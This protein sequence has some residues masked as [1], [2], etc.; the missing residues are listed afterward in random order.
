MLLRIALQK[1]L[2]VEIFFIGNWL[3]VRRMGR[4]YFFI[5]LWLICIRC[6]EQIC[7]PPTDIL[8]TYFLCLPK[9]LDF[10]NQT[11][12]LWS[13]IQKKHFHTPFLKI[14]N[15]CAFT[16]RDFS[17]LHTN[18]EFFDMAEA[19]SQPCQAFKTEVFAETVNVWRLL[20]IFA[21][22]SILDVWHVPEDASFK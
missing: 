22:C 20:G 7:S 14:R 19:Y 4:D 6:R 8:S 10:L 16:N 21:K 9:S 2:F 17:L 13:K 11:L 5:N 12:K 18:Y 1:K 3:F 15:I